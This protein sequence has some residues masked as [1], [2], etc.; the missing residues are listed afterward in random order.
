MAAEIVCAALHVADLQW[1][2]ERFEEGDILEEELLLQIFGAGG[3]DD[4][5][6]TFAGQ[7]QG[8]Q[9]VGEGLACAG[10]GFD[11]EVAFFLEGLFYGLG[12]LVLA[13]AVF[14]GQRG[15]REDATGRE[16]VVQRR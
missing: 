12:H 2:E 16:E 15:S 5:L 14:E 13:A 11:D 4:A 3:D 9:E 6:L 1:A 7:A 10:A 8:W